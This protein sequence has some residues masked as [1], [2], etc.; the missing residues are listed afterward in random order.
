[1]SKQRFILT[2]EAVN[3]LQGAYQ[4]T[5]DP[6][7]KT[8]FQ[9]VRLYG[10]GYKVSA[11]EA[12]CGCSRA[13]LMIWCRTYR[14][15][16]V[17]GLLDHRLGGNHA[18]LKPEQIEAVQQVLHGYTPEQLWG[19]GN[20]LGSAFWTV[21]DLARLVEERFGVIYQS[22]NSYRNLFDKCDFSVQ[23][24]GHLYRSRSETAG[25]AFEEELEKN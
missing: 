7:A 1:M 2:P 20:S 9:A 8:R 15:E 11:I 4:H 13:S 16:G 23:R 19:E 3:E 6:L 18:K 21:P 12:I 22:A 25:M 24:P 10:Q 17:T 5:E 14:Q